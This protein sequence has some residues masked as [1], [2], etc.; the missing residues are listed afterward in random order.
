[1][2]GAVALVSPRIE[3]GLIRPSGSGE[4]FS[5][6]LSQAPKYLRTWEGLTKPIPVRIEGNLDITTPVR[7]PGGTSETLGQNARNVEQ[8]KIKRKAKIPKLT[9]HTIVQWNKGNAP[10]LNRID[11]I[12]I[13]AE[14]HNPQVIGIC[15]AN[16]HMNTH[17]P[18]LDL[19]GYSTE[20]DN[21][22]KSKCRSQVVAYV[23]KSI[24]FKRRTDLEPPKT[25][26]IWL[27][28]FT[29]EE[30]SYLIN[31]GYREWASQG[32]SQTEGRKMINQKVRLTTMVGTWEKAAE[33]EKAVLIVGDWNVDTIPWSNPNTARTNTPTKPLLDIMLES[34]ATNNLSLLTNQSTRAQGTNIQSALDIIISNTPER[35]NNISYHPSRSDHLLI[36]CQLKVTDKQQQQSTRLMRSYKKYTKERCQ[37]RAAKFN[38]NHIFLSNDPD[39][40]AEEIVNMFTELLDDIAPYK[41]TV[42]RINHAPHITKETKKLMIERNMLKQKANN[43]KDDADRII[44]KKA[45]N[46]V[47]RKIKVDKKD[48]LT[49][50]TSGDINNSKKLWNVVNTIN[51]KK[52]TQAIE[53]LEKNGQIFKDKQKI[54]EVM[55]SHFKEKIITLKANL[56]PPT[57]PYLDKLRKTPTKYPQMFLRELLPEQLDIYVQ[58]LKNSAANGVDS[59]QAFTFKDTYE[60]WKY[61]ILH[62]INLSLCLG[63]FPAILKT[64]KILPTLKQGK[65]PNNPSSY[66][67]ISSL[68]MLAKI[69]ERAG[70]DQLKNHCEEHGI[71]CKEQHGGRQHHSTTTCLMELQE[72]I[73][74]SKDNKMKSALLGIDMS[75]AYDLCNLDL[76]EEQ[77]RIIGTDNLSRKFI[78]SFLKNRKQLVEVEGM[79]SSIQNSLNMGLCQG[80]R[81]SGLLFAIYTN[82]LPQS[83]QTNKM[84]EEER[85][86]LTQF[87]DDTTALITAT[88]NNKLSKL[89]QITY[90]KLENHL[91][92]L[93]MAINGDKT[94]LTIIQPDKE[95]RT[96]C[97]Q[98]GGTE[99]KHQRTLR[100]LGFTFS[101]NNKMDEHI[102][103]GS[104]NLIKSLRNKTSML[105]VIKPYCTKP[106]IANIANMILN[107]TL[108][109]AAPLWSL[110]SKTNIERV[111]KAQTK[112]ARQIAWKPGQKRNKLP[113]RQDL[114][115]EL[116]WLNTTQITNRATTSLI[117][118]A[119]NNQASVGI[120]NMFSHNK[121]QNKRTSLR[122]KVSTM[123]TTK[124]KGTNFLDR[125]RTLFNNLPSELRD[126]K[127]KIYK[128][129]KELK[130]HTKAYNN[131]PHHK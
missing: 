33:E 125:G 89:I 75:S 97:L 56:T 112:A 20:L 8:V 42:N 49:Q 103:K 37:I 10:Y 45:R 127:I 86:Y 26:M 118:K 90:N 34:A 95:G 120:N 43:S 77:L 27:E 121:D 51:G 87:I 18:S 57:E 107:S 12:K 106:Q 63:T 116:G 59:V 14:D 81:S 39:Y 84:S 94:Q 92:S 13:I 40:V 71:I 5:T 101:E 17:L 104:K 44:Y 99:I 93:E 69:V 30:K 117:K 68:S 36:K 46:L 111:Q 60:V 73:Q 119:T 126:P 4:G 21:L 74:T 19:Q 65:T 52:T 35:I 31:I 83:A 102:W 129:K 48:W 66:R 72:N 122:H 15:E 38:T 6:L 54:A 61:E 29:L 105:R 3:G 131:L 76:M 82:Q 62:L 88:T 70:F 1:M 100:V 41:R 91:R 55:N 67:P 11:D 78:S 53:E 50:Q 58:E 115:N 23:H 110:T 79:L 22:H 113:H 24:R 130:A 32:L 80:G 16:I 2:G 108:C 109:Y 128:F 124:R 47:V 114:F 64:T 85:T 25:P 96:I 28:I 9:S 123:N 98:A 7:T